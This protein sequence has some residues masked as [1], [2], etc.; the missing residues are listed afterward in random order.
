MLVTGSVR[1]K[2]L[3]GFPY[4][5]LYKIKTKEIRVLAIMQQKRRPLYWRSRK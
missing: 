4:S 3:H 1:R 5:L 2:N